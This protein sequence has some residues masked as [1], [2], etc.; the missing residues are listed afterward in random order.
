MSKSYVD[1]YVK[2]FFMKTDEKKLLKD[3]WDLKQWL[4]AFLIIK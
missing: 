3:I 1:I 4:S 2:V